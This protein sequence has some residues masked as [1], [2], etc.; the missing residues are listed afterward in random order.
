MLRAKATVNIGHVGLSRIRLGGFEIVD[1][2]RVSKRV[3]E[4]CN[5]KKSIER[6]INLTIGASRYL[7]RL[8]ACRT[9]KNLSAKVTMPRNVSLLAVTVLL[10]ERPACILTGGDR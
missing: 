4:G 1:L 8:Q 2:P 9:G 5:N 3:L 6:S 10:F 7:S